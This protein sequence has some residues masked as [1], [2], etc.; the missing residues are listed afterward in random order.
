MLNSS[1]SARDRSYSQRARYGQSK[2]GVIRGPPWHYET[3]PNIGKGG[4]RVRE[5]LPGPEICA[6]ETE[7]MQVEST[8]AQR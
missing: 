7:R 1:M 2:F 4:G 6:E 5:G 8:G 3:C